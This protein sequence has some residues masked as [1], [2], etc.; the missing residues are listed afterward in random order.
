MI[1][2]HVNVAEAI[3]AK[4]IDLRNP[5]GY[6]TTVGGPPTIRL[7]IDDFTRRMLLVTFSGA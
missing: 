6:T 7:H 4:E 1:D 3:D 2:H 5:W